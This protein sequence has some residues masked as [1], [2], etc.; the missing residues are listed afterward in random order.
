MEEN[1]DVETF[2]AASKSDNDIGAYIKSA[3]KFPVLSR[4]DERELAIKALAG[5]KEATNTLVQ[6]NLLLVVKIAHEYNSVFHNLSDLVQEGSLGILKAVPKYDPNKGFRFTTY[7][8]WW[9]RSM[10]LKYIFNNS[11]M[12]KPGTTN[13]QKKLFYN[14]RREQ[15]RLESLGIDADTATIAEN[16][17]VSEE[18]VVDMDSRLHNDVYLDAPAIKSDD[19]KKSISECISS[20]EEERPD[21]RLEAN[22]FNGRLRDKL[23]G[24][25]AKLK[26]DR[27]RDI[28]Y[29]RIIA[30]EP[31]TLQEI[32]DKWK[33][34]KERSRQLQ[35][36]ILDGLKKHLGSL[37][38]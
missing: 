25:A 27:A 2:E 1:E 21:I 33:I 14:L 36:G 15:R 20:P 16:L 37:E 31:A 28:F 6:S 32:G 11:H 29:S 19:N 23:D 3:K 12:I 8:G 5:D 35:A 30:E 24:F 9:V 34:S 26:N 38:R 10:I 13:D 18:E 4:D 7:A 17:N 22:D